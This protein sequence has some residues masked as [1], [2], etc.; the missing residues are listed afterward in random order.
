MQ[1]GVYGCSKLAHNAAMPKLLNPVTVR[2]QQ[3]V[4]VDL[5]DDTFVRARKLDLS[6]MLLEGELPMPLLTAARKFIET[7]GDP[8]EQLSEVNHEEVLKTL[9]NHALVVVVEPTVVVEED[10][11]PAHMPV[12]LFTLPQLLA[13]WNQTAVLPKVGAA[14]AAEFRRQPDATLAHAVPARHEVRPSPEPVAQ[15]ESGPD[16]IG[17]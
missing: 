8:E 10:Q 12:S 7:R 2:D 13:I 14:A 3:L 4:D 1:P 11:N 5:G 9:R 15:S 17:G 16:F 6:M